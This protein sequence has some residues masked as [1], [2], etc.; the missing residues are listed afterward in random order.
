VTSRKG[1]NSVIFFEELCVSLWSSEA[2]GTVSP[3]AWKVPLGDLRKN[4][5]Y[6]V[7]FLNKKI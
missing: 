7:Q 6:T 5:R 3:E 1:K 4:V 2:T